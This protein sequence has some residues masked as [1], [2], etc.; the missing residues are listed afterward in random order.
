MAQR[1]DGGAVQ[2]HGAGGAG[3]VVAEDR[4]MGDRVGVPAVG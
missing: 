4:E 2:E 1:A 3:Y